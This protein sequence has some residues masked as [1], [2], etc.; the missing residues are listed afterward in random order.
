MRDVYLG[1]HGGD[2]EEILSRGRSARSLRQRSQS[3]T[4]SICRSATGEFAGVLGH[5][6]MGK[7]TLLKTLIGVRAGQPRATIKFRGTDVTRKPAHQRARAGLGYV[8]QGRE[9]FPGLSVRDNLRMGFVRQRGL[10]RNGRGS[11]QCSRI[12]RG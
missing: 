1:K 5:N 9:I 4:A 6:G 3:S 10:R 12:F 11:K 7:T 8:P 2:T